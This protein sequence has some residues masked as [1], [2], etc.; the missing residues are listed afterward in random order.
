VPDS[1]PIVGKTISRYR[2]LEKLGGGGMGVVY[3][4]EDTALHRF[5]ALKFLPDDLASDAQAL[6]RF[7]RE[8]QAA[9]GLNHP[10]ICTIYDIGEENGQA[11]I[12]MELLEGKTLKH[13][14]ASRPLDPEMLL[15]LSIEIADALDAAHAKGIVHRDIKPANIFVTERGHAKIL[16]FGLAKQTR[17]RMGQSATQDMTPGVSVADLTSPGAAIGTVAYMSPE[18]VRGK[19]LDARTDLFSFG[20]VLYEMATGALPFRGETSGVITEAILNRTPAAPARLNP[21][22]P[23]KLE[24][25]INKALEKDRELRYQSAAEIRADLKRLRR[26]TGSG[27]MHGAAAAAPHDS[28]SAHAAGAG[29]AGKKYLIAA[30]CVILLGAAFAAYRFRGHSI[31]SSNVIAISHWHKLMDYVKLSP[32]GHA[33][34]FVSP[35]NGTNQVFVML[36]SGGDPL[37][38]TNDNQNKIVDSFSPDGT[39][40]YYQ[41]TLIVDEVWSIPTLGGVSTRVLAGTSLVPSVDAASFFYL[42]LR[43]YKVFRADKSS[44]AEEAIYDFEASGHLPLEILPFPDGKNLLILASKSMGINLA[45]ANT[46]KFEVFKLNLESHQAEDLETTEGDIFCA[47]W[48]VPGQSL[49]VSRTVNGITNLWEYDLGSRSP[50]QVTFGPGPDS[51]PL[52]DPS[53]KGIF[54]VN[55]RN[56]GFLTVYNLQSKE[57]RDIVSEQVMQPAIS[58]SG[59]RLMYIA[60]PEPNRE[61]LWVSDIDGNNKLKLVTAEVVNTGDWSPDE[62]RFVFSEGLDR[63]VPF[64]INTDGTNLRRIEIAWPTIAWSAWPPDA[65]FFY[66]SDIPSSGKGIIWKVDAGTLHAEPLPSDCSPVSDAAPGGKYLLVNYTFIAEY[67]LETHQ[68]TDLLPGVE[69]FIA[70][71]TPDGQSFFYTSST[72]TAVTIHRQPWRDGKLTG[73]SQV[74][75]RLPFAFPQDYNGNAYDIAHDL[76]SVAYVRRGGQ[77]DLYFLSRK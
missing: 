47:S 51:Y 3:R 35:V 59:K 30:L 20:V 27:Q 12:V 41:K 9:S 10:N 19:E 16:D 66:L 68:C 26:D 2:V 77:Y 5:V 46:T 74:V 36:T 23:P 62:N 39:L 72:P 55:G 40:I 42:K 76:S 17:V 49:L 54:F 34:A 31:S 29:S 37:Q 1:Q 6:E 33:V 38:I 69:S 57:S 50:E 44:L 64:I 18:Q 32:D 21:D 75:A 25:A 63:D 52:V 61:E 15:D 53:G 4:A 28:S 56:S 73:A 8:A 43:Q 48:G 45:A 65:G 58:P 22:V 14:I 7:R 11:Y 67:S 13:T 71:F 24:D 60:T 70:K